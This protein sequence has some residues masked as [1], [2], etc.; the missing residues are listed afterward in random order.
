MKH[1]TLLATT[2]ILVGFGSGGTF[3]ADNSKLQALKDGS[4][5]CRWCDLSEAKLSKAKLYGVDLK[6]ADFTHADLSGADLRNADFTGADLT[7]A[8]VSEADLSGATFA[9][10]E[11]NLVD[12]SKALVKNTNLETATCDW[13]TTLPKGSGLECVGVTVERIRLFLSN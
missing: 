12:F 2:C 3:A 7:G 5:S 8:N 11:I 10:A 13:T 9:G 6:G 4:K 1:A